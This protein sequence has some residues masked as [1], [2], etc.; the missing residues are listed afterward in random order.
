MIKNNVVFCTTL[1]LIFCNTSAVSSNVSTM[2]TP[3]WVGFYAGANAGGVWSASTKTSILSSFV[4]GSQNASY[5]NGATYTGIQSATG[6]TGTTATNNT[7]FIGGGHIGYNLQFSGHLLG[8]L[9]TDLQ[10]MTSGFDSGISSN[11]VPLIGTYDGGA[12]AFLPDESYTTTLNSNKRTNYLGTFRGR[13]GSLITP[14]LLFIGTGGLAYGKVS[15]T[16]TIMQTNNERSLVDPAF[17]QF[18]LDP[19][20]VTSG[21]YAK[22]IRLGW[23]VGVGGEWMFLPHWSAKIEYLYYDLGRVNYTMNP[24]ITRIP[25]NP[26]PVA[27]VASQVMTHFNGNIMHVGIS[28]HGFS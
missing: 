9:E 24:T 17:A 27:V 18:T 3:K 20:T 28:Y 8:G 15:S 11:T 1:L 16:A 19:E 10:A 12:Y 21:R 26:S 22:N 5:P 2:A 23:T 6:A 14:S 25:A 4:P 7:A 13:L